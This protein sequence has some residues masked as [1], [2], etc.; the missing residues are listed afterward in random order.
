MTD[1]IDVILIK[2]GR[3]WTP[4]ERTI[5]NQYVKDNG[6]NKLRA[7]RKELRDD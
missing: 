4:E 6:R 1:E 2:N 7:R 3:D 5:I